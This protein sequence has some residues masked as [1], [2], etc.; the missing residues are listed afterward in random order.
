[1]SKYSASSI[2]THCPCIVS[3]ISPNF[4]IFDPQER[5]CDEF[6]EDLYTCGRRVYEAIMG[7]LNKGTYLNSCHRRLYYACYNLG[8]QKDEEIEESSSLIENVKTN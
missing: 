8:S 4:H 5:S 3:S 2:L 6:I 1:M 7:M